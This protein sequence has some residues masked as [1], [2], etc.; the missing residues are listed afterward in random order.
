MNLPLR[1]SDFL[2]LPVFETLLL[3]PFRGLA[4]AMLTKGSQVLRLTDME[5]DQRQDS[6][7]R[8]HVTFTVQM[9]MFKFLATQKIP[10]F[11]SV[12]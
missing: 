9:K 11:V 2:T 3:L 10:H 5:Q 1:T 12:K 4:G 6:Y 7:T 8:T